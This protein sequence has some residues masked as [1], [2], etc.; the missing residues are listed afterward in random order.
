[1]KLPLHLRHI[2]D[3]FIGIDGKLFL[4]KVEMINFSDFPPEVLYKLQGEL[5]KDLVAQAALDT[6]GIVGDDERLEQFG[7]CQFGGFDNQADFNHLEESINREYYDCG[8]RGSCPVEGKL[9]HHVKAENGY[10][11]P[12]EIK[13]VKL[14]TEDLTDKEIADRLDIALSTANTHR[15]NIQHKIGANSKVGICRFAIEK[16]II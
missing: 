11:T 2:N 16:R 9:C 4:I 8:K 10:L 3:E 1:M 6:L 13:F 15:R 7:L 5:K 12:Q 14:I